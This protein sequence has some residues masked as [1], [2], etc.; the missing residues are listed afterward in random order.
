L[1]L[2]LAGVAGPLL[3]GANPGNVLD[4]LTWRS[5]LYP[6]DWTPAHTDDEGRF[7]HD[8]SYAGYHNGETP[9]PENRPEPVISVTDHG[10]DPTGQTDSTSAFQAALDRVRVNGSGTVHVPAGTYRVDGTL[11]VQASNVVLDGEGPDASRI[12]FT[13]TDGM[14]YDSHL[15]LQGNVDHSREIELAED[16]QPRSTV[17]RVANASGLEAGMH[18]GVGWVV[19][20][21]FVEEHGMQGTWTV[22]NGD[23]Q[24]FFR[25]EIE[26]VDATADPPVVE[27]DVPL[28]YPAKV[29]DSASLRVGEGYASECGVQDLGLANAVDRKAA[30]SRDQVHVLELRNVEDCWVENAATFASPAS[31]DRVNGEPAHVQSGGLL[32]RDSKRVTVANTTIENP[33]HR[34]GGGNGYLFEVRSSSEVLMDNDTARNG[35]HNF[36]QNWGFGTSGWV[37]HD[38]TST[39]STA[40]HGGLVAT[41]DGSEFHHSLAMANLVD[42]TT[43]N[44]GFDAVNRGDY[45]SGAGHTATQ[46]VFWNTQGTGHV[47]SLQY[48]HGYVI[49]TTPPLTVTTNPILPGGEGTRPED[50]T[51]GL[52]TG[53]TLEPASLYEDMLERRT[54][55]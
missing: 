25:R 9:I 2:V 52:G 3:A 6:E 27:L 33:Q 42:Q 30:L 21:A 16:G 19:T 35:R 29:R 48:G 43:L 5:H 22:F 11:A 40:E 17:V 36:I 14:S 45:S 10:A 13:K 38:S 49:G 7:L 47:R 54:G 31:D 51:E 37:L 28:R 44:D 18:V 32:V 39:G 53:A 24:P 46:S 20:D 50:Y 41:P 15:T 23:W 34:G 26:R 55:R 12:V 8:F 1:A 4:P